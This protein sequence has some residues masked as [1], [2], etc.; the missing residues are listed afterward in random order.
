MPGIFDVSN[1]FMAVAPCR[2]PPLC[3]LLYQQLHRLRHTLTNGGSRFFTTFAASGAKCC[4][5]L[6]GIADDGRIYKGSDKASIRA[7][8]AYFEVAPDT[9]IK[10]L[11]F[12]DNKTTG[13]TEVE[14][15][16]HRRPVCNLAGQPF[17][18]AQ[19][20]LHDGPGRRTES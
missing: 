18:S 8:H 16:R 6:Y 17:G 10:A 2:F 3:T 15:A 1:C 4:A 9:E 7:Y 14:D 12:D 5:R 19:A 20:L 11:S 13:I